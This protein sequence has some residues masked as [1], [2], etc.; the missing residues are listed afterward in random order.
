MDSQQ[1]NLI[2]QSLSWKVLPSKAGTDVDRAR[3]EWL[4]LVQELRD[5]PELKKELVQGFLEPLFEI[6]EFGLT[7]S[8][9]ENPNRA[10]YVRWQYFVKYLREQGELPRSMIHRAA[11][12]LGP[13]LRK[14]DA[15]SPPEAARRK[16]TPPPIPLPPP[17]PPP[18]AELTPSPVTPLEGPKPMSDAAKSDQ[19][20]VA[21]AGES[22]AKAPEPAPVAQWKYLP[23]PEGPDKHTESAVAQTAGCAGFRLIGARVRGKKHKHDG[24]NGDDW[25]EFA[26]SGAWTII[27][28]SDGAGS[29]KLSRVGA[30]EACG[31]A[32][33]S[34][35]AALEN[36]KL[37]PRSTAQDWDQPGEDIDKVKQIVHDGMRGAYQAIE[38][39]C[40]E[41]QGNAEITAL[42]GRE[43]EVNDFSATLLLA[44]HTFVESE[45]EPRSCVV[46]CQVG[47]GM[48]AAI[49]TN[50]E[51]KLLGEADTG[52]FSGETEFLTSRSK[53]E[54]ENLEKKTRL[55]VGPLRALMVMTDGVADDYFPPDPEM[56]RLWGDILLNRIVDVA[57]PSEEA[58][59]A[60]LEKAR[61]QAAK[62]VA[63]APFQSRAAYHDENGPQEAHVRS[64]EAFTAW[65]G[66]PLAEILRTP[67][68]IWASGAG[69]PLCAAEAA[70]DRLRVW[71]E[72][73]HVRGSFDDR[74]LVVMHRETLS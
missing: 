34:M 47:D 59:T 54:R 37:A 30:R 73:Y 60:A 13:R 12:R 32:V 57:T 3:S 69:K 24:T 36:H 38:C 27:A 40:A 1:E 52:G 2:E 39:A 49:T 56:A 58:A 63:D 31:A 28:V 53:L 21:A 55:Y 35:A 44:V 18:A 70:R 68:I 72:A 6:V 62:E 17:P 22:A 67:E 65:L 74:T 45:G 14:R 26:K 29:K 4:K 66:R 46:A 25:F 41:R 33:K 20:A 51:L 61:P 15:P 23:I 10:V 7:H 64:C 48:S 42:L 11:S 9:Q 19:N 43:P 8:R 71:L 50:G 16:E 5:N